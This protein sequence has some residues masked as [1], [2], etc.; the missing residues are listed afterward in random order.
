[1]NHDRMLRKIRETRHNMRAYAGQ[2]IYLIHLV[3]D[4]YCP[5]WRKDEITGRRKLEKTIPQDL[6]REL[7]RQEHLVEAVI[8][9]VQAADPDPFD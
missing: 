2:T 8:A 5:R 6:Y 3:Y 1:M 4:G 7:K 9:I